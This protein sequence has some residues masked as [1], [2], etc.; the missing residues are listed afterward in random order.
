[1]N[2][3][4]K[5]YNLIDLL[6]FVFAICVVAIHT[7]VVNNSKSV[8]QWYTLH[9]IF[10][11]AV[12]FLFVCSGFF[13]GNKLIN[14]KGKEKQIIKRYIKRLALPFIFW[15]F[16]NYIYY[17]IVQL[18]N[19]DSILK[20]ILKVVRSILFYPIG[21]L[22]YIS[23]TIVSVVLLYYFIK[24]N[25]LKLAL[26]IGGGAYIFALVCNSYYFIIEG[27]ILQKV[28]DLYMKLFI[29]ARNGVFVGFL[30]VAIGMYIAKLKI[31]N[32]LN[33]KR[34]AIYMLI[35]YI[36]IFIEVTVIRQNRYIDDHALFIFLPFFIGNLFVV[37]LAINLKKKDKLF[38][39]LR[40]L[41]TGIYYT[42]RPIIN[43]VTCISLVLVTK[44]NNKVLFIT[45]LCSCILIS[46]LIQKIDNRYLNKIIK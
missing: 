3:N 15:S 24:E 19:G 36:F 33:T 20:I 10:R 38:V 6:K 46:Y 18:H 14:N 35:F 22:W 17:T 26:F 27:T 2:T 45:T 9:C 44:T 13:I 41:S 30:F 42:H 11:L 16:I 39:K 7:N 40:N 12:P 8:F 28:V 21:A 32:A 5:D 23:A 37:C 34:S 4:T 25:K 31:N 1:M 43:I 29:S